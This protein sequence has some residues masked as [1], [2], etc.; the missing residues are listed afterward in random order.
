MKYF[1]DVNTFGLD[2]TCSGCGVLTHF[3]GRNRYRLDK[4]GINMV[5]YVYEFQCQDCGV[6]KMANFKEAS[7]KFLEDRCACGG[8]YR[9]D[10]PLFCSSCKIN[11][12]AENKSDPLG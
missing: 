12:T 11:K 3:T 5:K 9:R 4:N 8:Q 1:D 6:L 2:A 10:K 7:N